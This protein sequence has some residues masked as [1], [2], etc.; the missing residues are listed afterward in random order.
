MLL[1][2]LTTMGRKDSR[3]ST[4]LKIYHTSAT[5]LVAVCENSNEAAYDL[6]KEFENKIM[7]CESPF[8]A[9]LAD[10]AVNHT[11][12]SC[13]IGVECIE[14]DGKKMQRLWYQT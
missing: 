7:P 2:S 8:A 6:C 12:V 10:G 3:A 9:Q 13:E 1:R 4:V 5:V 11:P 14:L